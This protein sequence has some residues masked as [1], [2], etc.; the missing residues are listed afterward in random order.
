MAIA[1]LGLVR[2]PDLYLRM[3]S[4]A[5]AG[6]LGCGFIL[7]GVALARPE[8]PVLAL[9]GEDRVRYLNGQVSN[10][11]AQDLSSKAVQACVCT[12]KGKIVAFHISDLRTVCPSDPGSVHLAEGG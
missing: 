12:L 10:Q 7:T 2:L 6:T 1:A 3:H 9:T 4:V 11:V 5:K 8:R